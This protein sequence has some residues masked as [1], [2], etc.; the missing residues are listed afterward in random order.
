[1][2]ERS[3]RDPAFKRLLAEAEARRKLAHALPRSAKPR[4]S[5]KP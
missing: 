3:R 2:E 1:V 4:A 5:R